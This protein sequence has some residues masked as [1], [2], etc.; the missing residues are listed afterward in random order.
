M[1]RYLFIFLTLT[2]F[3]GSI[4]VADAAITLWRKRAAASDCTSIIDGK[5]SDLCFEED[6]N[7]L[8]VC[9]PNEG[10]SGTCDDY[11]E[12]KGV[13]GS[14]N[15]VGSCVSANCFTDGDNSTLTFEGSTDDTYE[16]VLGATDPIADRN[17]Y[18]PDASGTI[19]VATGTLGDGNCLELNGTSGEV[20]DSGAPCGSGQVAGA[21]S[22][23]NNSF[24]RF[25]GTSGD[26]LKAGQTV[27]DDSGNV[28]VNGTLSAPS[29]TLTDPVQSV[30]DKG[31]IVNDDQGSTSL[32][33]FVVK[34]PASSSFIT[35]DMSNNRMRVGDNTTNY[36][37]FSSTGAM[38]FA[39]S[40]TQFNSPQKIVTVKL[41]RD[42]T[43]LTTGD[44]QS[45]YTVPPEMNG[46]ELVDADASVY[47]TSSSGL[48]T[49]QINNVT[50]GVDM[51]TTR[52]TID[53]GEYSSYTAATAA[54]IN[55]SNDSVSTGDRLRF[56]V[57]VAGTGT[58]GAELRLLFRQP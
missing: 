2:M 8:Y 56:D 33:N 53:T 28:T 19:V 13:S 7:T 32:D 23:T 25:S 10:D 51:L 46:F 30:F 12:W 58:R 34:I 21:G 48:P 6:Q 43:S 18:L 26:T 39:G 3:F 29:M 38:S 35:V 52:I 22:S 57:D 9:K 11:S 44:G 15:Q 47:T 27:E 16:T 54:V 4:G 42:D 55:T 50:A 45:Y 31:L 37:Q 41:I 49:F 17:I 5:S 24:P 14:I 1:K 20:I 36:V 40:A